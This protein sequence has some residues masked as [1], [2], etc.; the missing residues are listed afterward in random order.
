MVRFH[1]AALRKGRI[2][3]HGQVYLLTTV[4][5]H[6]QPL[7][8]DFQSARDCI[9]AMRFQH[10]HGRVNS[11][12]F[13]V[14]P[15][16][17]HWLVVLRAGSL[18]AIMK[19]VKGFSATRINRAHDRAGECWQAGFHDHAL[20]CDEDLSVAARYLVTNPVRAGLVADVWEYPH[21][22]TVWC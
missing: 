5:R 21:W 11:L 13:V 17:F 14:M 15:D 10:E 22:D 20:R 19:S 18:S 7:L 6:R 16:H 3:L 4:T 12:A 8:A 9:G 1:S 2:D